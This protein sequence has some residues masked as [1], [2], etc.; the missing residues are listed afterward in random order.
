MYYKSTCII[1]NMNNIISIYTFNRLKKTVSS[2]ESLFLKTMIIDFEL[3]IIRSYYTIIKSRNLR[4]IILFKSILSKLFVFQ[5]RHHHLYL[6][7]NF[8]LFSNSFLEV[9]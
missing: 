9:I 7:N 6:F 3:N 1:S 8:Y 2:S 4:F 5:N